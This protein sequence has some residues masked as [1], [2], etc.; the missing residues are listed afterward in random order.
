MDEKLT[1]RTAETAAHL[2]LKRLAFLWAQG[3]GYS[4]CALEVS[5]PRCRYRADVGAYRPG[6]NSATAVF[7]CKQARADL[8]RDN[9]RTPATRERLDTVHR[10]RQILEKHLR[11]HYPALRLADSLFPEFDAHDFAAIEHRN[12]GRVLRELNALHNH[13]HA[14]AKFETLIKYR[15]ANLFFLVLPE[16]LYRE[17][18]IPVGWG[19][20]VETGGYLSLRHRPV[21]H[22]TSAERGL[23]FLQR[24]AR[25]AT[26]ALNRQLQITFEEVAA[27]RS[28]SFPPAL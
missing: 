13:L 12:Y 1:K 14:G 16:E 21:W 8:R 2:R 18:E 15:C 10:R 27:E 7:E 23:Q 22:D 19:V 4:A 25:G 28:R 26:R 9:C 5:L 3:Q 20:L 11:I 17:P 6:A 24:I